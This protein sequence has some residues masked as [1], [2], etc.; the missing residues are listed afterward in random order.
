[1]RLGTETLRFLRLLSTLRLKTCDDKRELPT[2]IFRWHSLLWHPRSSMLPRRLIDQ[3][4]GVQLSL[5]IEP[6]EMFQRLPDSF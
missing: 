6:A 1:M 2:P 4:R 3:V 5:G